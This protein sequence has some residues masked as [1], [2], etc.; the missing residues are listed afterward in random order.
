MPHLW[1]VHMSERSQVA[2][3]PGG[4]TVIIIVLNRAGETKTKAQAA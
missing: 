2:L 3:V 1:H 4:T